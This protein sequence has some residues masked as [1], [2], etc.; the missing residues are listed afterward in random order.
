MKAAVLTGIDEKISLQ[1]YPIPEARAGEVIVALRSAALNHRDLW[2]QKGQYAGLQFPV[3]PGSDGSGVIRSVGEGVDISWIDREIII[4]PGLHWGDNP[5]THAPT[6]KI[7][8]L[9]DN[10]TL[11]EYVAVPAENIVAKPTHL[12]FDTAAALPLAGLTGYRALISR[13]Q[14]KPGEKV[15]ITGIGG[16][17]S[18]ITAQFAL[19]LGAE[20]WCT[21]GSDEKIQRAEALGIHGG[22]NYRQ[23]DWAK[24]LR[25]RAGTFDVIIDSAAGD[26]FAHL[27]ELASLGGR[28]VLYGR[29]RGVISALNPARIFWKQLSILGSTMGSAADFQAMLEFVTANTLQPVVDSIFPLEQVEEALRYMENST[30]TGKIVIKISES[31]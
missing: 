10:G 16:G 14:T 13:A 15:L 2:I 4:N 26:G 29:T 7:L 1:D 22:V 24:T 20:V 25:D 12:S 11:A 18:L 8:G 27:I 19:A 23:E 3:I 30:Q 5:V 31:G 21:S 9:P 6:F 17:V 28:I